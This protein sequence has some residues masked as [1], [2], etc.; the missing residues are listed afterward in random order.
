MCIRDSG[1]IDQEGHHGVDPRLNEVEGDNHRDQ[2]G[3]H[4]FPVGRHRRGVRKVRGDEVGGDEVVKHHHA[5]RHG[6]H[7]A[8]QRQH[9]SLLGVLHPVDVPRHQHQNGGGENMHGDAHETAAG[10][11]GHPLDHGDH[12]RQQNPRQRTIGK[13]ADEDGDI[14]RVILQE[15][16]RREDGE[17][18]HLSLIHISPGADGPR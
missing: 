13:G 1:L 11:D 16:G 2:Q 14:R 8:D 15:G 7:A 17:V 12:H 3:L 4:K 18:D 5:R 10:A 6:Q 9:R